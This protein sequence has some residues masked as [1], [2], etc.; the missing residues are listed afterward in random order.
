MSKL[1]YDQGIIYFEDGIQAHVAYT[2]DLTNDP[3]KNGTDLVNRYN[4]HDALV[5]A[6]K[7][8]INEPTEN[9]WNDNERNGKNTFHAWAT[10]LA[11][12]AL[13]DAGEL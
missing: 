12:K 10:E 7:S 4:S 8:I 13:K 5:N 11:N 6:L 2:K 3:D 9:H 1:K